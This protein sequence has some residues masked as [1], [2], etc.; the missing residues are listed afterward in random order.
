V[1]LL[2]L[3]APVSAEEG[4]AS[5]RRSSG[6]H[7][8]ARVGDDAARAEAMLLE[9]EPAITA[10][11]DLPAAELRLDTSLASIPGFDHEGRAF[12]TSDGQ[13]CVLMLDDF[14]L[15]SR[16]S[17]DGGSVFGSE[18]VVGGGADQPQVKQYAARR[19]AD[20]KVYVALV[21]ADLAGGVGLQFTRSDDTCQ[22][23]TALSTLVGFGSATHGV[24][25]AALA[26]GASGVAAIIYRGDLGY[27][28]YVVATANSGT[29]WTTPVR[30]DT[31][32]GARTFPIAGIDVAIDPTSGAIHAVYAQDRG[33]GPSIWRSRSIDG[34]VSFS[35]E[36]SFDSIL[37]SG[38]ADSLNPDI[39]IATDGSIL[40]AFWDS[41]GADRIYA[42]RSTDGG[43]VYANVLNRALG[44]T[45]GGTNNPV[46]PVLAT[47]AGSNT[48]LIAWVDH[49]KRLSIAR[50]AT[51][52]SAFD[53]TQILM[54]TGT[55]AGSPL[56]ILELTK[57]ALTRTSS[58]NWV[59][60]WS[61]DRSDTY[62][63][64]KTDVFVRVST[65]DGASWGTEQRV[66]TDVAGAA[67]SSIADIA[68][69]G[70][71]ALF[72]LFQD[73]RVNGGRSADFHANRSA[74]ASPLA[75]GTDARVDADS[76]TISADVNVDPQVATDGASHVY[77]AFS[78][79]AT[80]PESDIYVSAS[81]NG[82]YTYA[83]PVRASAGTA[84][85]LVR[86]L[87]R[88]RA[89]PDGKVYLAYV[90]DNAAG[91]REIR[92]NRSTDFGVT[93][94]A[95]DILLGTMTS[96]DP[97]YYS[98]FDRPSVQL[99]A[100]A[101][102]TIYVAWSTEMNILLARSI[103]FGVSFGVAADVD[104][105]ARGFNRAP[106]LCAAGNAVLLVW[107]GANLEFTRTS[108][109]S[110][111]S[112]NR[113][114]SWG[115]PLQLRPEITAAQ[116]GGVGLPALACNGAGGA[117]AIWPDLRTDVTLQL[118]ANRFNGAAWGGDV[119]VSTPPGLDSSAPVATYSGAS[120]VVVAYEG[121]DG[122]IY[123][124]RST[125]GGA[126]FP[127]FQRLDGSVT[128]PAALS[129]QP[130][131]VA[132]GGTNVW[133]SWLDESPGLPMLVARRSG[134]GGAA[135]DNALRVDRKVPSGGSSSFYFPF[136]AATP[137][138]LSGAA[139]FTWIAER[140]SFLT[141]A[142]VNAYDTD[143][144]D[145]DGVTVPGDCDDTNPALGAVPPVVNGM[146]VS[147]AAGKARLSWTPPAGTVTDI[148]VGVLSTLKSTGNF[149]AATCLADGI[150]GATYDDLDANPPSGEAR[151][152][153]IRAT[154]SCGIGS[155]GDSSLA[156]DPRD[157]LDSG[158]V[159][160]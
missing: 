119:L 127:S 142:L 6:V 65:T 138:M 123:T 72:V 37:A 40:V 17:L 91:Q 26:T 33:A 3:A 78:A 44:V 35:A 94:S 59:V 34:G 95:T 74:T 108:V 159:C 144:L 133:V 106:R 56:G 12:G 27:D 55:A 88:L 80:G 2:A 25:A 130:R 53:A 46:V 30:I 77:V 62:A 156:I 107:E 41:I 93:W 81:A 104:Q 109:W 28:P 117:V 21:V 150:A 8:P 111:A 103:D 121:S 18:V 147:K 5:L 112:D 134:D 131:V 57:I 153:L 92:F 47:A 71:D 90:V 10:E 29:S 86:V 83:L 31:G 126:T 23:W 148:A 61:D 7:R 51:N 135:W 97:G 4:G 45:S 70:T 20:G 11:T 66:D 69:H 137:A 79:F 63:G 158:P 124:S 157:A 24:R 52:G 114:V 22:S 58:G 9:P 160:D 151:W 75:F 139:F 68:P 113:A 84:G 48:V 16:R 136:D 85:S 120:N 42:V 64:L 141:D 89:F 128:N 38:Q 146:T 14:Q 50:S 100:L 32:V 67:P 149:S 105:D 54:T 98:F 87:P 125:D 115:A 36:A 73:R 1:A 19:A 49:S 145:R 122:T 118:F 99:E 140:D 102:G 39:E 110:V 152:Y 132:D 43:T 116:G 143:D 154:S 129:L 60:G 76:T 82:G 13:V 155:Y 15:R 96:P 101:D